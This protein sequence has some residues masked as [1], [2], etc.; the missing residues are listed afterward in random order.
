MKT[1]TLCGY[2]GL[3]FVVVHVKATTVQHAVEK[4]DGYWSSTPDFVF[5]GKLTNLSEEPIKV[6]D[7]DKELNR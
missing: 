1:Y 3:G 6:I 5:E 2:D 7:A 4:T